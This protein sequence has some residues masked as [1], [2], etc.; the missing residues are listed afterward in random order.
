MKYVAPGTSPLSA[1]SPAQWPQGTPL[2]LPL[3]QSSGPGYLPS[4]CPWSR[5]V[6]PGTSLLS[7]PGPEQWPRRGPPYLPLVQS[8]GPR[9]VPSICPW[10]SGPGDFPSICPCSKAVA[11]ET[12]PLSAPDPKQWPRGLPLYLPLVQSSGPGDFPSFCP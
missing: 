8:S 12:S 11:S 3:V 4:T 1:P 2:Y 7:A 9:E 10:S 5:A 6:A